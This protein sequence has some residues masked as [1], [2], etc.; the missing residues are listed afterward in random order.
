[1]KIKQKGAKYCAKRDIFDS[2]SGNYFYKTNSL[3]TDEYY[4]LG[5]VVQNKEE[6]LFKDI[7]IVKNKIINED[8]TYE[9]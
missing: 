4:Y 9:D 6:Y 3:Y 5:R 2:L 8:M 1:M 7:Y